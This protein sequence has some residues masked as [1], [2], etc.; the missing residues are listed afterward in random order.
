M[1]VVG[2]SGGSDHVSVDVSEPTTSTTDITPTGAARTDDVPPTTEEVELSSDEPAVVVDDP[3]VVEVGDTRDPDA[4]DCEIV[5]GDD[6]WPTINYQIQNTSD[7][8]ASYWVTF[9]VY[10]DAGIRI[11][12]TFDSVSL[13]GPGER[14]SSSTSMANDDL[15]P[16]LD[17]RIVE[18]DRSRDEPGTVVMSHARGC[19]VREDEPW[20][21]IEYELV[22]ELDDVVDYWLT[23]ALYDDEGVRLADDFTSVSAVQP[24]ERVHMTTAMLADLAL[25]VNC[26]I[27]DVDRSEADPGVDALGDV[28]SCEV[29]P[30]FVDEAEV[31]VVL[32]NRDGDTW[33]YF[34]DVALYDA[35]GTRVGEAFASAQSLTP[36]ETAQLTGITT[37]PFEL[38]SECRVI[39]I[40]RSEP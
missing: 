14:V 24:G 19:E 38:V 5:I 3:G 18:I 4:G 11:D 37:V 36:S 31:T 29:A 9:G 39:S 40:I 23:F 12:D 32:T 15:E 7:R 2:C 21:M 1:F 28:D 10:D 27:L 17:C 22:N 8:T 35:T 6:G 33:D 16:P 26:R 30:D 34:A 13:V 25:P 20:S